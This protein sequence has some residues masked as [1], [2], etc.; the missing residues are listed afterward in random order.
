MRISNTV[1]RIVRRG[2]P[3]C[4]ALLLLTPLA[5]R[6]S[7]SLLVVSISPTDNAITVPPAGV[8]V[9]FNQCVLAPP[10]SFIEIRDGSGTLI[11]G[12][13]SLPNC[14]TIEFGPSETLNSG[15]F[16]IFIYG[17]TV[18][19]ESTSMS[20][21]FTV[22]G[23]IP[24]APDPAITNPINDI[25]KTNVFVTGTGEPNDSVFVVIDDGTSNPAV[26][27]GVSGQPSCGVVSAGGTFSIGPFDVSSLADSPAPTSGVISTLSIRASVH[28][29]NSANTA[30]AIHYAFAY[31]HVVHPL[32]PV[33]VFPS[34]G[35]NANQRW[36]ISGT[37]TAETGFRHIDV[38]L[39]DGSTLAGSARAFC[40]GGQ[41]AWHKTLIL[42]AGTH[43]IKARSFDAAGN[44]SS[45]SN[46]LMLVV[47]T[48]T[49][50]GP[51]LPSLDISPNPI[52]SSL[53][54]S[55]SAQSGATVQIALDSNPLQSC[56][57][58]SS[59]SPPNYSCGPFNT[60]SFAQGIHTVTIKDPAAN[61]GQA[62]ANIVDDQEAPL[63]PTVQF[64]SP[65]YV[66][67]SNSTSVSVNGNAEPL[68]TVSGSVTSSAGG[69]PL[70]F[71]ATADAFGNWIATTNVSTLNDG[72]LSVCV[73]S[74]D[75]VGNVSVSGCS[76]SSVILHATP[77]AA[78]VIVVPAENSVVT[79]TTFLVS[80][81]DDPNSTT[82]Q[83]FEG[84][85]LRTSGSASSFTGSGI[86]TT[87]Y[88]DGTKQIQ[89]RA[90]DFAGNVGPFSA[91]RTFTLDAKAP[92]LV[93]T[94]PAN[95]GVTNPSGVISATYSDPDDSS[96]G[97]C[98][99]QVRDHTGSPAMGTIT[100]SG[101]T[102]TF[103][104]A[105]NALT[106]AG[107][108][109]TATSQVTDPGGNSSPPN[110]WSFTVDDHIPSAPIITTPAQ[111]QALN[112]PQVHVSGSAESNDTVQVFEGNTFLRQ[113]VANP[114]WSVITPS[115]PDGSH[116]LTAIAISPAGNVSPEA[117]VSFTINTV[118][119]A[120]P[121]I[122]T[123]APNQ[124]VAP[125]TPVTGTST[126]GTTVT[127]YEGSTFLGQSA[128]NP[129]WSITP[130]PALGDG[131][132]TVTAFAVDSAGN[133]STGTSRTYTVKFNAPSQPVIVSPTEGQALNSHNITVS[134]T[135]DSGTTVRV[136]EGSTLLGTAPA[137]PSWSIALTFSEGP[138]TITADSVDIVN[139]VSTRA[140]RDFV[141]DTIAP[142][143]PRIIA[144]TSGSTQPGTFGIQGNA[145]K[146]SFVEVFEGVSLIG[147]TTTDS[148]G[149]WQMQAT[150]PTGTHTIKARATDAA[151]NVSAFS[152]NRTFNVDA[153]PPG[154]PTII[155]P[156]ESSI[157]GASVTV[158]GS[159][160]KPYGTVTLIENGSPVAST[161]VDAASNWSLT[162]QFRDGNH[163]I[164]AY[165]TDLA[166][167]VG[168]QSAPRSFVSDGTAP[169]VTITAPA[170]QL[171]P[172]P[173]IT[174]STPVISGTA[175]DTLG[176]THFSSG[177]QSVQIKIYSILD[178]SNPVQSGTAVCNPSC[179][180][181]NGSVNWTYDTAP[182]A[183]GAYTVTATGV[184]EAQ[185]R[186]SASLLFITLGN[187]AG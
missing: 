31:K 91:V 75:S 59:A 55:G 159:T 53:S 21:V 174:L 15:E 131:S 113:G 111:G 32:A 68:T 71:S 52:K 97:S 29:T 123:P 26:A 88:T 61:G 150:L 3:V 175:D 169:A 179:G 157:N 137:S 147:S 154:A 92:T 2:V 77:P 39:Y 103:T 14:N 54:V 148:T 47:S 124:T 78:P 121:V 185:N 56:A 33:I 126:S 160:T 127:L 44:E 43:T 143:P 36:T 85:T 144:P 110:S 11:S 22:N 156:A 129:N 149:V 60:S 50:T 141:I 187:L 57:T 45:D 170:P 162:V 161:G 177:L 122:N 114:S 108:P 100:T 117:S 34:S 8:S 120:A 83:I 109:Y 151:G 25:N 136:F 65:S 86:P 99:L 142:S 16:T 38:H 152:A 30:S 23:S 139:N 74:T 134:G 35:T 135:A 183:P 133:Q 46:S 69:T 172:I 19:G 180:S 153:T 84:A 125:N 155:D 37:A 171:A 70:I 27:C 66:N 107:S 165:Q 93:S 58:A 118:P 49:Q 41:C 89:A 51:V 173:P 146:G 80:G 67:A 6:A 95:G 166:G 145:E 18:G 130:S 186:G 140:T 104:S 79:S 163:A 115:L 98:S 106:A 40:A 1:S 90:I 168:P 5:A 176:A 72:T 17:I 128:A 101:L 178:Q 94:S 167:N 64:T 181:S 12:S 138:H 96:L 9:Q 82:I 62:K 13:L 116:T 184:D 158:S 182:L 76:S 42:S 28:L 20:S 48:D 119:P 10:S 105:H 164:T 112:T 7:S 24:P 81:T 73:T 87:L 4:I 63:A 102:C 132:H